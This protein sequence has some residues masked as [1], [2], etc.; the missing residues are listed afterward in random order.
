MSR[1]R[2][3]P[4][5]VR[6]PLYAVAGTS[7]FLL[8]LF[9]RTRAPQVL[10]AW[11]SLSWLDAAEGERTPRPLIRCGLPTEVAAWADLAVADAIADA[12]AYPP[13]AWWAER[14]IDVPDRMPPEQLI[15][16]S[17]VEFDS[18]WAGTT[19]PPICGRSG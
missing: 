14:G 18:E 19:S 7:E 9:G 3:V 16:M 8:W 15:A 12:Q 6:P 1:L 5:W 10:G 4:E 17:T 13:P 11:S 2:G